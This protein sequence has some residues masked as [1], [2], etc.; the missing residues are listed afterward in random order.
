[1]LQF[2][3][4]EGLGTGPFTATFHMKKKGSPD[5]NR[6]WVCGSKSKHK[7]KYIDENGVEQE[8]YNTWKDECVDNSRVL[9]KLTDTPIGANG[10]KNWLSCDEFPWNAMEEGGNPNKNSRMCVPG[11]QQNM[12]GWFNGILNGMSQEVTWTGSDGETKKAVKSWGIDW[13]SHGVLGLGSRV[14]RDTAWNYGRVHEKKFTY[15][16]FNSD[17]DTTVTGSAYE[18]FNHNLAQG[19]D[20][21]DMAEVIG[22]VNT[23]GN[24]KYSIAKNALCRAAGT[25]DHPFWHSAGGLYVNTVE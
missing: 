17:S 21:S 9:S 18:V 14:D 8:K 16:L 12:Q 24:K 25:H 5:T 19:G 23:L 10:N 20:K 13:A 22:A 7:Y 3:T 4:D 1:V 15:H 6:Q 2:F 11:W